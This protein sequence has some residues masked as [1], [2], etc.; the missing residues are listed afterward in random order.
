MNP[1]LLLEGIALSFVWATALLVPYVLDSTE[2]ILLAASRYIVYGLVS[3]GIYLAARGSIRFTR[4]QW[5]NANI[6]AFTGNI[7]YYVTMALGVRFAGMTVAAMII[8]ILPLTIMA[9]GNLK[10]KEIPF[11]RLTFPGIFILI[12]IVGIN[13]LTAQGLPSD[14]SL[15]E[16]SL[17]VVF[18]FG[19]LGFWTWYSVQNA[20]W[21]KAHPTVSGSHWS[22]AVGVCSLWQGL[23]LIPLMPLMTGDSIQHSF[24]HTDPWIWVVVATLY[25]GILNTWGTTMWW[26]RLARQIP[27]S[28]AGQLLV[29][30]TIA[31]I[32]YGHL[33]DQTLPTSLEL[34]FVGLQITGVGLGVHQF[35]K[36]SS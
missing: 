27:L 18:S 4:A 1:I 22:T 36:H 25:M 31:S 35:S 2:P 11:R 28:L 16:F 23:L 3:V 32:I 20:D 29:F 6:F 19:S 7:G 30:A 8:G 24:T 5:K 12:G 9:F 14:K 21:L 15:T 34:L 17:G 33:V 13:I 10:R 26:N